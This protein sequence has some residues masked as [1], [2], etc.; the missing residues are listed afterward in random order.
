MSDSQQQVLPPVPLPPAGQIPCGPTSQKPPTQGTY[1]FGAYQA[2]PIYRSRPEKTYPINPCDTILAL[3]LVVLGYLAWA[4]VWPARTALGGV[5]YAGIAFTLFVC[6]ALA[7]S[8]VYFRARKVRLTK[9]AILAAAVII[10]TSVPFTLYD[11]TPVHY[12]AA[13][14]IGIAYITWHAYAARTAISH[15]LGLLTA[16]DVLN[17]TIV[18]PASNLGSWFSAVKG[19]PRGKKTMGQILVAIIGVGVALPVIGVVIALLTQAD[20][21]FSSWMDQLGQYILDFSP[22]GFLW[23]LCLAVPVAI[24]L[25]ALL[26]GN[27]HRMGTGSITHEDATRWR[28]AAQKITTVA[29]VTP[30]SILCAIYIVFFV[31]MGSNLFGAFTGQP[32]EES[33]YAEFARQGFFQ[34]T[35]VAGI[36][37]A[38]LGFTYLFAKRD[39]SYPRNLRVVGTILSALTLLLVV[40]AM[41][42]MI[43]Y[44]DQYGLTRLRVYTLW[45]MGLLFVIFAL[46]G[47]WHVRRFRVDIPIIMVVMV[48]FMGLTWANTDGVIAEYNVDHYL[49]GE[50]A[51]IDI[52]YL[53]NDLSDASI[54]PLVKLGQE[55]SEYGIRSEAIAA[56]QSH[57]SRDDSM[58]WTSWNWQSYRAELLGR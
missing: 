25:F 19:L 4:W 24:Y 5:D 36:N 21:N 40:T 56:L 27:A 30:T 6:L 39:G 22:W 41:S 8:M 14:F 50:M 7:S 45:F 57:L 2:A 51:Q 31:A 58:V 33:T 15:K 20:T 1:P 43:L 35:A 10:F 13:A 28:R 12:F 29:L 34:L 9:P 32:P 53:A 46:V 26:Y 3:A 44:V 37:L 47:L 55:G 42:K 18:V 16:V 52:A 38:V 11:T 54:P 23:K 48:S 17:Q 49:R